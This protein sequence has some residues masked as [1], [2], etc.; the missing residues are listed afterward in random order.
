MYSILYNRVSCNL[1]LLVKLRLVYVVDVD[2]VILYV[3]CCSSLLLIMTVIF[4]VLYSLLVNIMEECG[5]PVIV[6]INVL[7]SISLDSKAKSTSFDDIDEW[8]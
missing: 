8:Y 4:S 2:R 5:I 6:I 7:T 3:V 1:E